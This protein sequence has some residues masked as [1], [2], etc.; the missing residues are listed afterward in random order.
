[1]TAIV[2]NLVVEQGTDFEAS[3]DISDEVGSPLDLTNFTVVST[4]KKSFYSKTSVAFDAQIYDAVNGVIK[5]K[6][7]NSVSSTLKGGRYVYD[8]VIINDSGV[9]KR[10]LEGVVTV[11]EGVSV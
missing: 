1:M 2:I 11:T 9:K 8:I 7:S 4:L 6:L 5:L 3:F 10:V